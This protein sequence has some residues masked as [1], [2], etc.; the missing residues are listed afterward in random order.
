LQAQQDQGMVDGETNGFV[1][2]LEKLALS[3]AMATVNRTGDD[4]VC[5]Y[6]TMDVCS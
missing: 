5:R 3:F 2:C 1:D 6:G 4:R